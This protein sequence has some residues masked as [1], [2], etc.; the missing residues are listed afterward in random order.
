MSKSNLLSVVL[1]AGDKITG[2][3]P[4]SEAFVG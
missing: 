1:Q 3:A 4:K 2:I